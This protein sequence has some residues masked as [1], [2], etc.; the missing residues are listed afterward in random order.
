M[1]A[2]SGRA[3]FFSAVFHLTT[4]MCLSVAANATETWIQTDGSL[5]SAERI[6]PQSGIY[7][8]E[9]NLGVSVG[10]ACR[11]SPT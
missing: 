9:E 6:S 2:K 11:R 7:T 5:G 4:S 1:K 10:G 3:L 8:I